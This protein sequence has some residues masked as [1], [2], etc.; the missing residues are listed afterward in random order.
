MPSLSVIIPAFNEE[1]YIERTLLAL[2]KQTLKDFEIIVKDGESRDKTVGIAEKHA[3]NVIS[4]RDVSVGDARNQG[5]SCANGDVLVFVDADTQLPP[6]ALER[7]AKLMKANE[8]V[9][10]GSCRKVPDGENILNRLM[11]E[12]VNISTFLSFYLHIGGAHGNCMYIK[13]NVFR[14]IGGFNPKIKVAEEQ[15]FVRRA[16]RF[17][18]FAF[19]LD[20]CVLENSRRIK[21]WGK[22]K[23]Y[24]SWFIGTFKSFKIWKK[25][26]YEKV[27]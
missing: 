3:D 9:I 27:R 7:V 26:V 6:R 10:G 13:K 20:L 23:L 8:N 19:L 24:M 12:L 25:Q 21:Q 4:K 2:R 16:M 22:L 5:A 11:Y 18:K 15:E 1:H 17:G 14:K